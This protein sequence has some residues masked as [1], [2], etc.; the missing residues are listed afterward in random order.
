MAKKNAEDYLNEGIYGKR[1]PKQGERNKFLGTLRERIVIALT[2]G[3][4]MSD[5]G[6]QA[7]EKAMNEHRDARL[8]FN[9]HVAYRF[10][11]EEKTLANKYNIPYTI[12]TNE[13]SETDIGAV[14]TYDHAVD[15]ETIYMEEEKLEDTAEKTDEETDSF[16]S[17]VKKWFS[18]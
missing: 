13:D 9:G 3:Q 7:L 14:L 15:L 2:K 5:K 4:V 1:L 17:K 16:L 11:N 12:I 6:L 10:L 18:S 8:L